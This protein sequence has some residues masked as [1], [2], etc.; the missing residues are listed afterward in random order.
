[1]GVLALVALSLVVVA[2]FLY[3]QTLLVVPSAI[4]VMT[5]GL[6]CWIAIRA[7]KELK[8]IRDRFN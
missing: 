5:F 2:Y 8:P 4:L 1:M 3:H 6:S 7:S